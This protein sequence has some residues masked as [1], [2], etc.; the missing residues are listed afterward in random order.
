ME[1]RTDMPGQTAARSRDHLVFDTDAALRE[2]ADAP[3]F[4]LSRH[5]ASSPRGVTELQAAD[6]LRRFGDNEPFRPTDEGIGARILAAACVGVIGLLLPARPLAAGLR[7]TPPPITYL[8]W[9][10]AVLVM[11]G[12][13]AQLVKQRYLRHHQQWL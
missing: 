10:I 1:M 11:Y 9:L 6:R 12:A 8:L 2:L 5:V 13:A 7:M 3:V 4:T